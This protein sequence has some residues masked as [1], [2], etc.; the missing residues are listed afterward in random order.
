VG[1]NLTYS[2]AGTSCLTAGGIGCWVQADGI[3]DYSPFALGD[4]TGDTPTAITLLDSTA[5]GRLPVDMVLVTAVL[6]FG[7]LTLVVYGR[8]RQ[9]L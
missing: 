4:T 9:S 7:L 1:S 5:N 8:G 6:L 2:E 3:S